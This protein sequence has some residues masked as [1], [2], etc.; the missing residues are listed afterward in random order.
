[1][2]WFEHHTSDRDLSYIK[3]IRSKFGAEGYGIYTALLEV[4]GEN[5]RED[6]QEEWGCVAKMHDLDSLA[7]EC[8]IKKER[9][10]EFLAY[11]DQKGIFEKK[12]GRLFCGLI[13]ERLDNYAKRIKRSVEKHSVVRTKSEPSATKDE[14]STT[15]HT[16]TQIHTQSITNNSETSSPIEK[17]SYTDL[18]SS[19]VDAPKYEFQDT[20]LE[21]IQRLGVPQNKKS[22]VFKVC[23]EE[24]QAHVEAAYRFAVDYP[25]PKLKSQMF[26]WKLNEVKKHVN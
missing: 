7:A 2:K 17:T 12:G 4:I 20:A 11:C 14:A 21:I 5:V 18:I 3:I 10:S 9:L 1:M 15:L 16:H 24:N 6:N 26:F 19:D 22:S 13:L 8:S 25:N 23:K